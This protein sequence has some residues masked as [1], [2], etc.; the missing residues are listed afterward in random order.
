MFHVFSY[1]IKNK[2]T[3]NT[4][5]NNN[6]NNNT[7]STHPIKLEMNYVITY[8]LQKIKT[9]EFGNGGL[10]N[11]IIIKNIGAKRSDPL[12]AVKKYIGTILQKI[13]SKWPWLTNC[14]LVIATSPKIGLKTLY[15]GN[16]LLSGPVNVNLIQSIGLGQSMGVQIIAA[17][18]NDMFPCYQTA[19][20]IRCRHCAEIFSTTHEPKCLSNIAALLIAK[21]FETPHYKA[22]DKKMILKGLIQPICHKITFDMFLQYQNIKWCHACGSAACDR[23]CTNKTTIDIIINEGEKWYNTNTQYI[24]DTIAKLQQDASKEVSIQHKDATKNTLTNQLHKFLI[25]FIKNKVSS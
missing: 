12:K 3:N 10:R 4:Q 15:N 5:N 17:R 7:I 25:K 20:R 1:F 8:K 24:T 22:Y 13:E 18:Y 6:N 21:P 19:S 14:S 11:K 23:Y 16:L 9:H 2:T